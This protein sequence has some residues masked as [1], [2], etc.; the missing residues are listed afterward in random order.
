MALPSKLSVKETERWTI[1]GIKNN[2]W[3]HRGMYMV[4]CFSDLWKVLQ[5]AS[6]RILKRIP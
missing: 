3:I 5:G 4:L 6:F 1:A 2:Q